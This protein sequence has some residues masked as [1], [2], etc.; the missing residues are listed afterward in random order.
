[1]AITPEDVR[2]IAHLARIGVDE[3]R[4]EEYASEL[5]GVLALVE[6]MNAVDTSGVEPLSHPGNLSSRLREDKVSET[7]QRSELQ[8]PAPMVEQGLFLVPK[9]ID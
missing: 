7:D 4:V 1:M 6:Q 8:S 3:D 5:S 9:V 2:N